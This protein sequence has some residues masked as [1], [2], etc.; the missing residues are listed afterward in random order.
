VYVKNKYVGEKNNSIRT[1]ISSAGCCQYQQILDWPEHRQ[2]G[3][4]VEKRQLIPI[5][6]SLSRGAAGWRGKSV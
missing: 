3:R 1:A 5:I 2:K 6:G 4:T